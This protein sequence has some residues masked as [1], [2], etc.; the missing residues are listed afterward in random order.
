MRTSTMIMLA[1]GLCTTACAEGDTGTPEE[2]VGHESGEQ[3]TDGDDFDGFDGDSSQQGQAG[4]GSGLGQ[5]SFGGDLAYL[6]GFE[7]DNAYVYNIDGSS[8]SSLT[9]EGVANN[10]P[11]MVMVDVLQGSIADLDVG[12][13]YPLD[14]LPM[15][16][17]LGCV[18]SSYETEVP[19]EE[20][21]LED[22]TEDHGIGGTL[23]TLR[24]GFRYDGELQHVR[25]QVT[26]GK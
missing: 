11:V 26:Q 4:S 14:E 16:Y 5:G 10:S 23:Y 3:P 15:V 13:T 20:I 9:L 8:F 21:E 6:S 24:L 18:G 25:A 17:M 22:V 1:L 7:V 19:G 12:R 2:V